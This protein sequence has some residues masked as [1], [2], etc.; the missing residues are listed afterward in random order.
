MGE[1]QTT[2]EPPLVSVPEAG[3]ILG[4]ISGTTI[5]RLTNKGALEIRKIGSRTFITMESIRRLAEQ[6]SD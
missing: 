6:G 5:W 4:G 3:K 2:P 1:N